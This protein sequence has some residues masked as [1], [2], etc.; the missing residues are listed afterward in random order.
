MRRWLGSLLIPA[1]LLP[2]S[3]APA[4]VPDPSRAVVPAAVRLLIESEPAFATRVPANTTQVI[5]TVSSTYWCHRIWCTKTQA[6]AK[7]PS[8]HWVKVKEFRSSI[9]SNGWGKTVEG[10]RRSPNGVFRI[11]VTF[12]TGTSNPG[13]MPWKRRLPTSVM[14][15]R[16]GPTYNTWLEE[17]GRTTGDRPSMRWGLIINY[18]HPR[19]RIG[20][21]PAPVQGKGTG[22]FMHTSKPGHPWDPTLGC[23]QVGNP[24]SMHWLLTWL[25][26]EKNP[27]IV[28][29][30]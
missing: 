12:S 1:L 28:Q 30:L 23:T 14:S 24:D 17:P 18:N 26:P 4:A 16:A 8:G 21:G 13:R 29:N 7:R 25:K 9:G 22:I 2:P 6:W 5:R 15:D 3:P 11:R 19:L 27:R 20:V 10:D